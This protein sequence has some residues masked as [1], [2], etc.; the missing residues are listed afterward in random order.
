MPAYQ[1]GGSTLCIWAFMFK[2][3]N[4]R[5]KTAF[6]VKFL[7]RNDCDLIEVIIKYF[8]FYFEYFFI[9]N[10]KKIKKMKN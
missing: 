6:W 4:K 2:D 1:N 10:A 5:K 8:W 3:S 7:F 9:S